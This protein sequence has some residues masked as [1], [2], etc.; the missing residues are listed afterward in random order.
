MT[1]KF[2]NR[3][4]SADKTFSGGIIAHLIRLFSPVRRLLAFAVILAAT[5]ASAQHESEAKPEGTATASGTGQSTPAGSTFYLQKQLDETKERV[6]L[7]EERVDDVTSL[8]A[9]LDFDLDSLTTLKSSLASLS[10]TAGSIATLHKKLEEAIAQSTSEVNQQPTVSAAAP[11]ANAVDT[12]ALEES[13]KSS[14]KIT[15]R[16]AD[17]IF[18]T[19]EGES[20][21][22]VSRLERIQKTIDKLASKLDIYRRTLGR[23]IRAPKVRTDE[24]IATFLDPFGHSQFES[25][26]E[27]SYTSGGL[28][29]SLD[30]G[31]ITRTIDDPDSGYPERGVSGIPA[32]SEKQVGGKMLEVFRQAVDAQITAEE[33][34]LRLHELDGDGKGIKLGL[35][36]ALKNAKQD[37]DKA[38]KEKTD[39]ENAI[40]ESYV[41]LTSQSRGNP[42]LL[43]AIVLM[44]VAMIALYFSLP[45]FKPEIATKIIRRRVMI[46]LLSMG[47]LLLTVIILGTSKLLDGAALAALLGTMAGY[48]FGRKPKRMT[49]E[50][51]TPARG[52]DEETLD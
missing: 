48:I 36:A 22:I 14:T 13:I 39:L 26:Y 51:D 23:L 31:P 52:Q 17:L 30:D 40:S 50:S 7:F 46:E 20:N 12:L 27:S 21:G 5:V 2:F 4:V 8:A 18:A 19:L 10:G 15:G 9:E 45:Y 42:Y 1:S 33:L 29:G 25:R 3:S 32:E 38:S 49:K 16:G 11:G 35:D 34:T 6:A 37:L 28:V 43:A 41:N 24:S 44:I 47:F